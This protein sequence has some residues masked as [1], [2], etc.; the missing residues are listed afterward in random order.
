[1]NAID[2]VTRGGG[3]TA[4]IILRNAAELPV[5]GIALSTVR[6][7]QHVHRFTLFTVSEHSLGG[8]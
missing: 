3:T 2:L 5:H 1:V 7:H 6:G 4:E 8:R